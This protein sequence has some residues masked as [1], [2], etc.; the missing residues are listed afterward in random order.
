MFKQ[1]EMPTYFLILLCADPRWKELS[2]IV[3]RLNKLRLSEKK[4][5]KNWSYQERRNFLNNNPAFIAKHFQ[6]NGKVILKRLH[7]MDH[8]LKVSII[9]YTLNFRNRKSHMP[10]HLFGF[11]MCQISRIRP[12]ILILL[13][14]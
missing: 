6:N 3:K 12:L 8:Q 11:S 5:M 4:K 7:L 9:F 13:K 14:A 2:Y 1:L 10:I